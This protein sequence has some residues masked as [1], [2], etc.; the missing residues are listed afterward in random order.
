MGAAASVGNNSNLGA[1]AEATNLQMISNGGAAPMPDLALREA[2]RQLQLSPDMIDKSA[3]AIH[4]HARDPVEHPVDNDLSRLCTSEYTRGAL[5]A[6]SRYL[7]VV[8]NYENGGESAKKAEVKVDGSTA[9]SSPVAL[10]GS[11]AS[12]AAMATAGEHDQLAGTDGGGETSPQLEEAEGGSAMVNSMTGRLA[13]I[14]NRLRRTRSMPYRHHGTIIPTD[15]D[16][17]TERPAGTGG[18]LGSLH[19]PAG[20]ETSNKDPPPKLNVSVH[21]TPRSPRRPN[22]L[23]GLGLGSPRSSA[24]MTTPRRA[25]VRTGHWKLGHEIGKGSFGAVHIGLNEDSGDLIAVKVLSL[26]NADIAEQLYREIELMRQ[27]THPNIVC[28]LGAEVRYCTSVGI[29]H[30]ILL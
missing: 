17:Q 14:L 29:T 30:R 23:A 3:T 25:P 1:A 20:V 15:D 19:E 24:D 13:T 5:H 10:T 28:Y 21:T 27:L 22:L 9:I 7:A 2:L 26:R 16:A 12:A 18:G 8:A 4:A 11:A 6:L